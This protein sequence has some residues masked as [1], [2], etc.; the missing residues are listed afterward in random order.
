MRKR[1]AVVILN[2]RTPGLT[3]DCL[4]SLEGEIEAERDVVVV[5][6]NG[7]GDGSL[8]RIQAAVTERAWGPWVALLPSPVNVGFPAGCNLGMR[9]VEAEAYLLLNND[10]IVRPG[11]LRS[12]WKALQDRPDV[13]IVG[14]RLEERDGR[15]QVSCFRFLS[16]ISEG[17][18]AARTGPVTRLLTRYAVP[19][20][21]SDAPMEPQWTCFACALIRREVIEQVGF[22]EDG[23]FLYF[24][25]VDYCRRAW[26]AGWRVLYWPQA[27]VVH[28]VGASNPLE[29]ARAA[30][31]RKPKYYYESRARYFAKF[32]GRPG[33]W[34][35][36]LMWLAGRA[37]SLAREL[38]GRKQPHLC[39]REWLDNWTNWLNPYKPPTRW[40]SSSS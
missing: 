40:E 15:A 31:R 8:E 32:Y 29:A 18:R 38:V 17:L 33:L 30:R 25:D 13:G 14:S 26:N 20:P 27:R 1:V 39:K 19:M 23:Y 12:L 7:S 2:Y 10:T 3:I 34:M 28:L 36:N 5:V 9:S 16:P 22:M 37:V 35:A 11:A 24:D 21:V 4:A 6:E